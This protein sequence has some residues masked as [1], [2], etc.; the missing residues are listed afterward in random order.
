MASP[1]RGLACVCVRTSGVCGIWG[2]LVQGFDERM[3]RD[4]NDRL[5]GLLKDLRAARGDFDCEC[6]DPA[7]K[8]SVALTLRE[9][10][11]MRTVRGRGV[12]SPE[13]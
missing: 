7:C 3:V 9:Y 12:V 4:L 13:H 8:R 6:G 11:A 2:V 10:E 1:W 5:Y